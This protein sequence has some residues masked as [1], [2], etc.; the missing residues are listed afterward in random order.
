MCPEFRGRLSEIIVKFK[1]VP[2]NGIFQGWGFFFYFVKLIIF[3]C[4]SK[5]FAHGCVIF[6]FMFSTNV[7]DERRFKGSEMFFRFNAENDRI[8]RVKWPLLQCF[9][10]LLTYSG[11]KKKVLTIGNMIKVDQIISISG[12]VMVKLGFSFDSMYKSFTIINKPDPEL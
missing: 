4:Q 12:T 7:S 6:F 2:E 10:W 8:T 9:G 1:V 5:I 3:H 11:E